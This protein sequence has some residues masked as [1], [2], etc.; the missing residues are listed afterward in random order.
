MEI[1]INHTTPQIAQIAHCEAVKELDIYHF[2]RMNRAI[3]TDEIE[4]GYMKVF[5]DFLLKLKTAS[6]AKLVNNVTRISARDNAL[7]SNVYNIGD[8]MIRSVFIN[9]KKKV[10]TIVWS[11]GEVTLAKCGANDIWDP[12][13]GFY[14]AFTKRFFA[15]TTQMNKF[16]KKEIEK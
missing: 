6:T 11:D 16:V 2:D 3:D 1:N 4:D 7:A 9:E 5:D 8:F 14:V 15:S 13:K 12:E 10:V